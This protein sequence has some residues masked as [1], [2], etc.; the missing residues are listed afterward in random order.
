LNRLSSEG[1]LRQTDQRGFRI[2]QVSLKDLDE[3][4]L[5]RCWA[6]E[7]CLRNSIRNGGLEWEAGVATTLQVL[8]ETPR[9]LS[10]GDG[11]RNPIW[12]NAHEAFHAALIAASGSSW[13]NDFC[14]QLYSAAERYRHASRIASK[15]HRPDLDEHRAIAEATMARQEE[16]AVELLNG[17]FRLTARLVRIGL[18]QRGYLPKV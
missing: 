4:T 3:L 7:M 1:L 10:D 15:T 5:A 16:K 13:I 9:Y 17:H 6:N 11:S 18:Q 8:E 14:S 2:Q 12:E